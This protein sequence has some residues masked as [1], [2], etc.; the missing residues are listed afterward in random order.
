MRANGRIHTYGL[1]HFLYRFFIIL[2]P[3]AWA[4]SVSGRICCFSILIL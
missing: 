3:A 4:L 2:S 1:N